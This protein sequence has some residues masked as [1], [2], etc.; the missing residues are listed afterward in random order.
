MLAKSVWGITH[1]ALLQSWAGLEVFGLTAAALLAVTMHAV[2]AEIY[3]FRFRDRLP[4]AIAASWAIHVTFNKSIDGFG[5]SL[6]TVSALLLPLLLLFVG[7]WPK[8]VL[9][10]SPQ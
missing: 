7:L 3:A 2:T 8:S 9:T 5:V 10:A 6:F 1:S 4:F